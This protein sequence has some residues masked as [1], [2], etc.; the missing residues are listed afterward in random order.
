[1]ATNPAYAAALAELAR[2]GR[3]VLTTHVKPDGDGLGCIAALRRW[4][5]GRGKTI[6]VVLPT[7][8]P[9][10]YAFLDP[11]GTF[12]VAG[13]DLRVEAIAPPDLVAVLDTGT[14]QQLAVMKPL[15]AD[16][17][18]RVLVIDHHL[19]QDDGVADVLLVDGD[20]AACASILY[21]LL[22]EGGATLTADMA[23]ALYAGLA[24]DTSWFSLPN[25]DA[26]TLRLAATLL[27]AGARP[28][29]LYEH[30]YLSE[31]LSKTRLRGLAVEG[32]RP[33]LGGRVMVM[34][35]SAR[36]FTEAEASPSDTEDLIN[37]CMRI[38]GVRVGVLLVEAERRQV[39]VSLR[40]RLGLDILRVARRFGGG[41]H[42]RAAGFRL[43]GTLDEAEAMVLEAVRPVLAAAGEEAG[44]HSR[45]H[46][47]RR[48][49]RGAAQK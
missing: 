19:T 38:R 16:S 45:N 48:G 13:R 4:L 18:A 9:P 27:E 28:H 11:D 43:D 47:P 21:R 37:E 31:E 20:A 8:P 39:R 1:M 10:K 32:M 36:M 33:A 49:P 3:I 23:G 42:I 46:F 2:A 22:V 34:R 40:A 35:L 15:V 17:G 7:V 24:T 12:R 6:E 26:E 5:V 30:L 14:W 44:N 41:G 29:A 25:T